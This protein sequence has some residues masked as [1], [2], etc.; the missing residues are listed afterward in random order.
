MLPTSE[1]RVHAEIGKVCSRWAELEFLTTETIHALAALCH[2][3]FVEHTPR[4]VVE[5]IVTH[6][7]IRTRI[8]VAKVLVEAAG[9]KNDLGERLVTLL[10]VIDN[11][12]RLE[13]NR[14]IHDEWVITRKT[15]V[16]TTIRPKVVRLQSRTT[17]LVFGTSK[18]FTVAEVGEFSLQLAHA[19]S[20]LMG[21]IEELEALGPPRPPLEE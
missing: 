12:Y 18:T 21:L 20:D 16:R 15:A 14:F 5:M 13:R 19:L 7:D 17:D 8:S 11:D 9:L 4:A 1:N 10:N 2:D 6:S 3:S